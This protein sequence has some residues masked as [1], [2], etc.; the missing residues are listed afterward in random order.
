MAY[1]KPMGI[2]PWISVGVSLHSWSLQFA[3]S[4]LR[5]NFLCYL[6]VVMYRE[7]EVELVGITIKRE[8]DAGTFKLCQWKADF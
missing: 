2:L 3:L 8:A 5:I 7:R 4:T 6:L 1:L